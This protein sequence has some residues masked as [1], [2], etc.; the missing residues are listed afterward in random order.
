MGRGKSL[1]NVRLIRAAQEI[2]AEIQPASVRAVCYQLFT[3]KLIDSMGKTHT[4]RVSVQL[5]DAREAG[6]IPWTWIVDE[7]REAEYVN[8]WRDP[9]AYVETVSRA[10]R[11]DRWT[12]QP[13][14]IEVWS[15]KGTVRGTL[16]PVLH[17]YGVTF[18]VM[19][20]Y[21]SAT[22]LH[23]VAMESAASTKPWTVF[24][25]GDWD[26]SGLH[27][28][29]VDLPGRLLRYG[30]K[31]AIKRVALTRHHV[32]GDTLP[33]FAAA[34][35]VHDSRYAWYVEQYGRK[36]WELDALNPVLLRR[37]VEAAIF[38]RVD[39]DAWNRAEV[40]EQAERESLHSILDAWPGISRQARE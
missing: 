18:R 31:A 13:E 14:R 16:A 28:S 21:G 35:K 37:E 22:T 39:A 7:T 11:R 29:E 40:V 8:A 36:C 17:E 9:A 12:D 4:N 20:G 5:R 23:D 38:A 3:R 33:S 19:H 34:D 2:L 25:V 24:Y 6:D 26:P 30:G 15:E 1:K 27:M 32:S 10:Y